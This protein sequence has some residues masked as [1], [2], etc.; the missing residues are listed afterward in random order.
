[1]TDILLGLILVFAVL[2]WSE[3]SLWLADR[4]KAGRKLRDHIRLAIK[5]RRRA[6]AKARGE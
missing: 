3:H 4:R 1:M 5:N 2:A 6:R